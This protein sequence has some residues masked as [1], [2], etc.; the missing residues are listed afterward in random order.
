MDATIFSFL[1]Q[2]G[3]TNGAI[4]ALLALALVL[5]FAVTRILFIPQ[6]EFVAFGALT[7]AVLAT[8]KVPGTAWLLPA[9]GAG[10]LAAELWSRRRGLGAS[11]VARET[12]V[13]LALPLAVLGVVLAVAPMRPGPAVS[14]LLTVAIV[15][16]MGPYL[17]R[18]AFQPMAEASIL[19]LFIAAVAVHLALTGLALLFFGPE[20]LRAPPLSDAVLPVGPLIVTGQN[21]CIY[22][23]AAALIAGLFLFFSRSLWGKA[24]TA[25]AVNRLGARLVGIPAVLAGKL[26]F[27]MAASIGAVS[28]V[29]I[30]PMTTV[31]YDSGFLIGLKGFI[32]AILGGLASFPAAAAAAL[33]VG[34][35][36]AFASFFASAYKE[37]IVFML[38]LPVLFWRSLVTPRIEDE[39][40]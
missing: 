36:E 24:L 25:T 9:F 8:G 28:G 17:Y 22:A 39:D 37:I 5:V 13:K 20:G 27:L 2:D 21:L 38:I 30:A 12:A 10:A 31:Y 23:L 7:Y 19:A 40:A 35:V 29:M 11:L 18:I 3:V 32:A 33:G 34:L 16:P 4:Y 6:G 26:A 1:V 14:A 15:A